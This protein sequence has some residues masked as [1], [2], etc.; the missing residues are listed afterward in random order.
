MNLLCISVHRRSMLRLFRSRSG[1]SVMCLHFQ[2]RKYPFTVVQNENPRA[3]GLFLVNQVNKRERLL[4]VFLWM[5][6][7][8]KHTQ[9][10]LTVLHF[11]WIFTAGVTAKIRHYNL[12]VIS[13]R[14][15]G[16]HL[17][18]KLNRIQKQRQHAHNRPLNKPENIS[19]ESIA[20][21]RK[22]VLEF[23]DQFLFR[24]ILLSRQSV[25]NVW[26]LCMV[27]AE[28]EHKIET[29][30]WCINQW[31]IVLVSLPSHVHAHIQWHFD[32]ILVHVKSKKRWRTVP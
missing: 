12:D 9:C 23:S 32:C 27:D 10:P 21:I 30:S 24:W 2:W 26:H 28:R 29:A 19:P 25:L 22:C 11:A 15:T 4:D 7:S 16:Y 6:R 20:Y 13:S 18:Y 8:I 3:M 17:K 1:H 31:Q 5:V 14:A